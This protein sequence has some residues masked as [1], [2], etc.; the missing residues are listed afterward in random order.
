MHLRCGRSGALPFLPARLSRRFES[1]IVLGLN[2]LLPS[3]EHV[4]GRDV[5]GGAVKPDVIVVVD[6]AFDQPF[7]LLHLG[8]RSVGLV[9]VR[10]RAEVVEVPAHVEVG[11]VHVPV[12][13]PGGG[14]LGPRPPPRLSTVIRW[15]C[16]R[17]RR[18]QPPGIRKGPRGQ[19]ARMESP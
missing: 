16:E 1:L 19:W 15:I 8:G 17:A 5:V 14:L 4:L 6:V 13:V 10:D 12:L 2:G 9:A 3:L 18:T 7:R 11:D